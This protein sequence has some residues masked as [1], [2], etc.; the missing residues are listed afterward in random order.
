VVGNLVEDVLHEQVGSRPLRRFGE[1]PERAPRRGEPFFRLEVEKP[2]RIP[3]VEDD[4]GGTEDRSEGD[5]AGKA[6]DGEPARPFVA[7]AGPHVLEGGVERQG[8]DPRL[9]QGL[10]YGFRLGRG[11]RVEGRPREVDLR[12]D[13]G[14]RQ[15]AGRARLLQ[16][17]VGDG[18]VDDPGH[19][20]PPGG[21]SG[22]ATKLAYPG[23]PRKCPSRLPREAVGAI[24][25]KVPPKLRG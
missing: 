17:G 16:H 7:G 8:A 13:A 24:P 25:R 1:L 10:R 15:H 23:T 5:R 6:A 18:G 3:A 21:I 22:E 12:T 20:I 9:P 4:T 2:V 14:V 11:D 19:G